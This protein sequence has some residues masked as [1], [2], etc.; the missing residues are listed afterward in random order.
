MADE[1]PSLEIWPSRLFTIV[2]TIQLIVS[3]AV[4]AVSVLMVNNESWPY[5][6]FTILVGCLMAIYNLFHFYNHCQQRPFHPLTGITVDLLFFIMWSAVIVIFL[7]LAGGAIQYRCASLVKAPYI[8]P[9]GIDTSGWDQYL[10][11]KTRCDVLKWGFSLIVIEAVLVIISIILAA[12][13]Q[14]RGDKNKNHHCGCCRY[15]ALEDLES[16]E[17]PGT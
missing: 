17:A 5:I 2:R 6:I 1:R 4:I 12:G 11:T 7:I 13:A 14:V 8:K 9:A 3:L 16:C 10:V 15:K